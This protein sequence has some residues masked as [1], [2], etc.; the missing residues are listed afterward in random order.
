MKLFL[1]IIF[2]VFG[3]SA[4]AQTWRDTGNYRS[5]SGTNVNGYGAVDLVTIRDT[6]NYS[7]TDFQMVGGLLIG[8]IGGLEI[9]AYRQ[10]DVLT[11]QNQNSWGQN[12]A[13]DCGCWG[14]YQNSGPSQDRFVYLN[15]MHAGFSITPVA[16]DG[17]RL[18]VV[19]GIGRFSLHYP[20]ADTT[21]ELGY[22]R[23]LIA[24]KW[25]AHFGLDLAKQFGNNSML[26]LKGFVFQDTELQFP[27]QI[28]PV[29]EAGYL[30]PVA[31][32]ERNVFLGVGSYYRDHAWSGDEVGVRGIL[33]LGIGEKTPVILRGF[34][35]VSSNQDRGMRFEWGVTFGFDSL[36]ENFFSPL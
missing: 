13:Y 15:Y 23:Q 3:L 26:F 1:V 10:S 30:A 29:V 14:G 18:R 24:Q 5:D 4:Q 17:A 19:P 35:G 33:Q 31:Q 2:T 32:G 7:L 25:V 6:A 28:F 11:F 8:R 20:A 16:K 21:S 27:D 36:M 9:G 12:Y 34:L 22:S